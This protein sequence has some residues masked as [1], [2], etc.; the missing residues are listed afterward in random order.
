M[1]GQCDQGDDCPFSH[2]NDSDDSGQCNSMCLRAK[3]KCYIS[4]A[5]QPSDLG[6]NE[7]EWHDSAPSSPPG[8]I[9]N[10]SSSSGGP[11]ARSKA[12]PS[13]IT[14]PPAR[15]FYP[16]AGHL[17]SAPATAV[18]GSSGS[19]RSSHQ[20]PGG[21]NT[22][23]PRSGGHRRTRSMVSSPGSSRLTQGDVSTCKYICDY[24]TG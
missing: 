19:R 14:V 13:S 15:D 20:N 23:S 6:L 12:R 18:P 5:S 7:G 17:N 22:P 16:S 21:E 8:S 24:V 10:Y 9:R 4:S 2:D 3:I 1:S 11:S